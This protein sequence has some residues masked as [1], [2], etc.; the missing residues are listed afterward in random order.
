MSTPLQW[1]VFKIPYKLYDTIL[2]FPFKWD[3]TTMQL[4]PNISMCGANKKL[5]A[6]LWSGP[7]LFGLNLALYIIHVQIL[8]SLDP[9]KRLGLAYYVRLLLAIIQLFTFGT[10]IQF[11]TF[12]TRNMEEMAALFT[13]SRGFEGAVERL[14]AW[15]LIT[16]K[17]F[18]KDFL[19]VALAG[20]TLILGFL[21]VAFPVIGVLFEI[22]SLAPF[23]PTHFSKKNTTFDVI[24]L[25]FRIVVR[26]SFYFF[27]IALKVRWFNF[28][29]VHLAIVLEIG[30]SMLV[31]VRNYLFF[32]PP[33]YRDPLRRNQSGWDRLLI[34]V[35][36]IQRQIF[37]HTQFWSQNIGHLIFMI[38]SLG[39]MI[40][41][42]SNFTVISLGSQLSFELN[43]MFI[44]LSL[45]CMIMFVILV[46]F[47]SNIAINSKKLNMDIAQRLCL[48]KIGKRYVKTMRLSKI[49]T[50]CFS[51][52]GANYFFLLG[53]P[54]E[55]TMNLLLTFSVKL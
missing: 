25:V 54:L 52:T 27:S 37:F 41:C 20:V 1:F 2:P 3:S 4:L 29:L 13:G 26:L 44:S 7:F 15:Y 51:F 12:Y 10:I 43:A 16:T 31:F 34:R 48:F 17:P 35:L 5:T 23:L 28:V 39:I 55:I 22:D 45:L 30:N 33:P 36:L 50:P 49:Y 46:S 9:E 53:I 47:V 38:Y 18:Y 19:G 32:P 8:S 24:D 21:A 42:V 11:A 6:W 14:G 40:W